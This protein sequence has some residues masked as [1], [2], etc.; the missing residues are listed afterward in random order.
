MITQ[1]ETWIARGSE[2][3]TVRLPDQE[4]K[5]VVESI[6]LKGSPDSDATVTMIHVDGHGIASDLLL[7]ENGKVRVNSKIV[8]T[9][10]SYLRLDAGVT[11]TTSWLSDTPSACYKKGALQVAHS[12]GGI[13]APARGTSILNRSRHNLPTAFPHASLCVGLSGVKMT[14]PYNGFTVSKKK[15]ARQRH[16]VGEYKPSPHINLCRGSPAHVGID[17][18]RKALQNRLI[19][20]PRTRGGLPTNCRLIR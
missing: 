12:F 10:D 8:V 18:L 11:E 4:R 6:W 17:R 5:L 3:L 7:S 16:S 13:P 14:A 20:L 2:E 9:H 15:I 19:R 1:Q